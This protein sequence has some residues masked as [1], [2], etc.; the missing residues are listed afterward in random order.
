MRIGIAQ[1]ACPPDD[2]AA[3][4]DAAL[5]AIE[6][7][8]RRGVDLVIL[9]EMA[10]SG[11]LLDR[12][13]VREVA[14]P[15]DGSG[16]M[17]A[18]W[19]AAARRCGAA[20]IGG[21]AEDL[22][23]ERFANSVAVIDRDGAIIG[24]YRK[25]HLFGREHDVFQPG[26]TGLPIVEVAGARV[27]LLV[28]YDLRFPEAARILALRGAQMIAVPTAWVAGFD[29]QT[30][31]SG[32]IGQVDGVVVQANL[33]QVFIACADQVG[34]AGAI[35]FLGRSVVVDPYGHPLLGPLSPTDPVVET[36]DVDLAAVE[37]AQHRGPGIDPRT[38]RRT[39]VYGHLLGYETSEKAAS[40]T[41]SAAPPRQQFEAVPPQPSSTVTAP[42]GM[43]CSVD[44][45]ASAAGVAVLRQGGSAADA[46]I[47]AS[48][49]LAVTTPHMCG[50]GGDL[51]AVVHAAPGPPVVL[52]ASGRAGSGADPDRLVAEG[53]R[54]MPFRGD[55]RSAPVPG[56]VDGWLALHDRFGRVPLAG[57]LAFAVDYAR[58]GFPVS[59]LLASASGLLVDVPGAPLANLQRGERLRR[60]GVARAL[61]AI[62]RDGRDGF[63]LGEFGR[64]LL[65]L[66]AGEYSLDDLASPSA[67]WVEPLGLDVW[68]HH[69]WTVP[70]NSQGYLT[71]LG[72]AIAEGLGLPDDPADE[73]W[74]YLLV[75]AARQAGHDRPLRLSEHAEGQRL[76]A[77]DEIARRRSLISQDRR[78]EV[79][80]VVADGG[81]IALVAVDEARMGVSLI[82]SNAADFGCHIFEP[83]TGIGLHN[84]GIGFSLEPGHPARYGPGRRPPS[85]LSPA[86][87]TRPDGSLHAVLGT[88]GGDSQPQI[89]LQLLARTLHHGALPGAA[90][91]APRWVLSAAQGHGFETWVEPDRQIVCIEDHAPASW[92]DGL[93]R[94]GHRTHRAG[95]REVNYGHA[96]LAAV[97]GDMLYGAAD[98]RAHTG[99]AQGY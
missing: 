88:Q 78:A 86:L 81:T 63:Y 64:G 21:F 10:A 7:A 85:T 48:A 95:W 34:S 18:S 53:N 15:A 42:A 76:L 26:D 70:P 30:P 44:H 2:R 6:R 22:G 91:A 45:L 27:G 57:V 28:C 59:P 43:V 29:A 39:D 72:A 74:P 80:G 4:R 61:E 19:A 47:A 99:S 90:L 41:P 14:E 16:P 87:V 89:L 33:N 68:G 82:Q 50:M 38:N 60:P 23:A 75:E 56:C 40:R 66:G 37:R 25:L 52:N 13:Q 58:H 20:L 55:V 32:S 96:H 11:Y 83:A 93:E 77:S 8:T 79:A 94:R 84:R 3:R 92:T 36:V 46:A 1:I 51:F 65:E 54:V 5:A 97:R 73:A 24:T 31:P 62:I 49:V 17:L 12:D 35:T 71:L 67:D 9:P 98:P 69:V